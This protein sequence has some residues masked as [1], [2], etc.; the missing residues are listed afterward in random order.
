MTYQLLITSCPNSESAN[1]LARILVEKHLA[2]CVNIVPK[3]QSI[4]EWQGKIVEDSE[5]LL[6][7]KT[8]D[9]HYATIEKTLSEH[10]SY[11]VPE[12]IALPIEQGFPPYLAWMDEVLNNKK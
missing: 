4:Y 3:I 10:H 8:Q 1:K 2:A 9:T 6:L 7:I 11:D 5:I 12:L